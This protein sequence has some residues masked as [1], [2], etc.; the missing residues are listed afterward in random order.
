MFECKQL[1]VLNLS[2]NQLTHIPIEIEKL[3]Q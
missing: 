2:C 3:T 1:N